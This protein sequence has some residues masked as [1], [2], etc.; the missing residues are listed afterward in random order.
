LLS[1]AAMRRMAHAGTRGR[2]PTTQVW[3]IAS[4][5]AAF[6]CGDSPSGMPSPQDAKPTVENDAGA[7]R[8]S[9]H[10]PGCPDTPPV[11]GDPCTM[12]EPLPLVCEYA[13]P[14][15]CGDTIATCLGGPRW[16]VQVGACGK[17]NPASCPASFE[18][19]AIG[20]ACNPSVGAERCV[21][22][23]GVCG[24]IMCTIDDQDAGADARGFRWSCEAWPEKTPTCRRERLGEACLEPGAT[25]GG[26]ACALISSRRAVCADGYWVEAASPAI[27]C[28]LPA[29]G[30]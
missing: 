29:C 3:V 4:V 22:D 1:L 14:E 5:L 12:A 6:A 26:D 21:Y 7:V 9:G 20:T 25:C 17:R 30:P 15:G 13:G 16:L 18:G 27:S 23:E 28:A 10:R 19:V 24:C 8:H 2:L 11:D